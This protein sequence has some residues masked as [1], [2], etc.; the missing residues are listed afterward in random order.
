MHVYLIHSEDEP[1]Y[2]T[3][4]FIHAQWL[5]PQELLEK[6]KNGEK[7]KGDLP[8]ILEKILL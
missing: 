2:N 1:H 8:I 6:I 7:A 3:D 4:D 5:K